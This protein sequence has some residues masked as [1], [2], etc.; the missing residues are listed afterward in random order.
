[1]I[2]TK[3]AAQRLIC[4]TCEETIGTTFL[5][6]PA[7]MDVKA[8]Q[9]ITLQIAVTCSEVEPGKFEHSDIKCEKV[10]GGP[11]LAVHFTDSWFG[12]GN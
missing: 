5:T 8:A 4:P 9:K 10:I 3:T 1:M 12:S 2:Q 11:A 7:D 6:V